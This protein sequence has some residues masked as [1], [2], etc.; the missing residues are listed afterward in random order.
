MDTETRSKIIA[1]LHALFCGEPLDELSNKTLRNYK[2]WNDSERASRRAYFD[3]GLAGKD[4]KTDQGM[5][6]R[7]RKRIRGANM[8]RKRGLQN[9]K[10]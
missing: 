6:R 2:A 3:S 7:Y 4:R 9:P 5:A 1:E 10:M 8:L